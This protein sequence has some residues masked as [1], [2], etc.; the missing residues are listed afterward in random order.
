MKTIIGVMGGG[1]VAPP[2]MD[3]ARELGRL[4]AQKGWVL[5][6]GG[7]AAGVMDASA[8]GAR[9]A[10]GLVVGI[11]P[12]QDTGRMSEHVD[13]PILT[14][15]GSTRNALN[16][17]SSRVVVALP[18]GTGTLSEVAL[19]LTFHRPVVLL[20]WPKTDLFEPYRQEGR[21]AYA[22]STAHA[23]ELVQEFL[24]AVS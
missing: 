22:R 15:M 4:I 13:V 19:A 2:V 5:L 17:L 6:T 9:E 20:G 1:R 24:E 3:M 10:G 7:R 11:L 12:D 18:G 21:L 16:V 23:V 14:G 8:R